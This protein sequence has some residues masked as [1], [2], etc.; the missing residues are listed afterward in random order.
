[1]RGSPAGRLVRLSAL[2][3]PH[4]AR[5]PGSLSKQLTKLGAQNGLYRKSL[6]LRARDFTFLDLS[7]ILFPT[8]WSSFT[9]FPSFVFLYWSVSPTFYVLDSG[10]FGFLLFPTLP[11]WFH[12]LS[13]G[14]LFSSFFSILLPPCTPVPRLTL[15]PCPSPVFSF[16]ILSS[17]SPILILSYFFLRCLG[18]SLRFISARIFLFS[19]SP[20]SVPFPCGSAF[21]GHPPPHPSRQM[22]VPPYRTRGSWA[23][24]LGQ[25]GSFFFMHIE[26][27]VM[28]VFALLHGNAAFPAA[29]QSG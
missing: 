10:A 16:L 18:L 25:P 13:S 20:G 19:S 21:L 23:M 27:M 2:A 29:V 17:L 12:F 3:P 1:M 26:E 28:S 8:D 22:N 24:G 4:L 6:A 7:R 14:P 11:G 15:G 9:P 5:D